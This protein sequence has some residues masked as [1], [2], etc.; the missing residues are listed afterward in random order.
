MPSTGIP[1]I[2]L[3]A[4]GHRIIDKEYRGIR[5]FRRLGS[6]PEEDAQRCLRLEIERVESETR[7]SKDPIWVFPYRGKRI[8]K[9]NNT[10]W[11]NARKATATAWQDEFGTPAPRGLARVRIHDLRHTFGGR[12]RA[13]GVAQ[14]DR[15]ALLGHA[16]QT[17]AGLYASADV[18]R[19]IKLANLVLKRPGTCTVL[20]VLSATLAGPRRQ[21]DGKPP[22]K[23]LNKVSLKQ[24]S[25]KETRSKTLYGDFPN[26]GRTD[27]S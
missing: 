9:M 4:M 13:A 3:N 8:G 15:E 5:I 20:R 14:E 22:Y 10:A 11:K 1:G 19:L 23:N 16:S 26:R 27:E 7:V 18:G 6:M 12:L 24:R 21:D 2:T 17:M 25:P